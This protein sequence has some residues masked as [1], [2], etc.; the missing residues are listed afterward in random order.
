MCEDILKNH[1][2][3]TPY[4]RAHFISWIFH[5]MECLNKQDHTLLFLA[6]N[7]MDRY[8]KAKPE[9]QKAADLQLNGVT[10]LFIVSKIFEVDP[11]HLGIMTTEMCF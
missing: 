8:Y 9:A 1:P 5:V 10:C 3:V 11:L 2:D 4:L 7:L 6:I